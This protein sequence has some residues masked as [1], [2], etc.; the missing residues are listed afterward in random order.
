MSTTTTSMEDVARKYGLEP[1]SASVLRLTKLVASQD[2]DLDQIGRVIQQDKN[3]TAVLLRQANPGINNPA[4]YDITSVEQALLRNGMG[5]ILLLAMSDPI[6]HAVEKTFATM[7][8]IPVKP[9]SP[10][11]DW[12]TA[13][14]MAEVAFS[15]KASGSLRVRL[16]EAAAKLFVSRLIG[17]EPAQ[18]TDA[19]E[20]NDGTGELVNIIVGNFKSNLCDAGLECQLSAPQIRRTRDCEAENV[21]GSL[22]DRLAVTANNFTIL[23]DV[24]V[25][26]WRG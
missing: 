24:T 23:I 17:L 16:P 25:N 18:L 10:E 13:H 8:G 6:R 2:A 4:D 19:S 11:V 7:L 21:R 9:A 3:L 1:I 20:I 22:S 26:P 14:I 15:G 12:P 5:S